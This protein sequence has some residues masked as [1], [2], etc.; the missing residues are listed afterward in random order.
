MRML[1]SRGLAVEVRASVSVVLAPVARRVL[2]G[3][4]AR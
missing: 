3:G 2:P 4:A 1:L